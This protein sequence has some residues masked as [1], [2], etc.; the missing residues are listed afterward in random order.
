MVELLLQIY[1]A[2]T[3]PTAIYL[4][5]HNH[6]KSACIIGLVSQ[7]GF[8]LLF[9]LARQWIMWLPCVFYTISWVSNWRGRN[10][11]TK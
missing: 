8:F 2:L 5:G 11:A 4:L 1:I 10:G 3:A 7:V 6:R 9:G